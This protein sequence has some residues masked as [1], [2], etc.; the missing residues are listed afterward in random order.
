MAMLKIDRKAFVKDDG[1]K[2]GRTIFL[3]KDRGAPGRAAKVLPPLKHPGALGEGF[4][5]KSEDARHR[6]LAGMA[7]KKGE[8]VVGGRMGWAAVMMK[9]TNP[10]VAK[11]A[12]MDRAWVFRHFAGR[13][14]I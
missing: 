13:K 4:F 6:I 3:Q 12:N 11:K 14:R 5:S 8:K 10:A 7:A 1:T 2:V 9:N